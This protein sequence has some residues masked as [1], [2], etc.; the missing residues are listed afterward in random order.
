MFWTSNESLFRAKFWVTPNF[1]SPWFSKCGPWG[2]RGAYIVKKTILTHFL[3]QEM[4]WYIKKH[5]KYAPLFLFFSNRQLWLNHLKSF[6]K[7]KAMLLSKKTQLQ[8]CPKQVVCLTFLILTIHFDL[9]WL[10]VG[11]CSTK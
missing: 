11:L 6:G 3:A 5:K 7:Q 2:F 1:Q 8:A 4:H 9:V 10:G